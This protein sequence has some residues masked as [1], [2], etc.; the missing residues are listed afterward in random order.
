[1]SPCRDLCQ[2]FMQMAPRPACICVGVAVQQGSRRNFYICSPRARR[3]WSTEA[4]GL[5]NKG[6]VTGSGDGPLGAFDSVNTTWATASGVLI[7]TTTVKRL[8]CPPSTSLQCHPPRT[9]LILLRIIATVALLP[10]LRIASR[11]RRFFKIAFLFACT[12]DKVRK[13]ACS[14][15][16]R[17]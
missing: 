13:Q 2:Q 15:P 12:R 11:R 6:T 9:L 14:T 1:V 8:P 3:V 7:T 10:L 4:S 5:V 17:A 16:R